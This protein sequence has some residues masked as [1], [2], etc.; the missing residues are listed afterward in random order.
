MCDQMLIALLGGLYYSY[1][2]VTTKAKK[3][4]PLAL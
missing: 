3:Q 2:R 4:L 1:L